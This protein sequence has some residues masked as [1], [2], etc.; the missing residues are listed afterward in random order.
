MKKNNKLTFFGV[1]CFMLLF[2]CLQE[3]FCAGYDD[4]HYINDEALKMVVKIEND[5]ILKSPFFLKLPLLQMIFNI[6]DKNNFFMDILSFLRNR[7][8]SQYSKKKKYLE[9]N[10]KKEIDD[11][12][13]LSMSYI[14]ARNDFI[15]YKYM[16]KEKLNKVKELIEEIKKEVFKKISFL[17]SSWIGDEIIKA[18]KRNYAL[19][20]KK[21]IFDLNNEKSVLEKKLS[22]IKDISFFKELYFSIYKDEKKQSEKEA[23]E[24]EEKIKKIKHKIAVIKF[25]KKLK[26]IEDLMAAEKEERMI[27]EDEKKCLIF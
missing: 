21:E 27:Y 7:G 17:S 3:N 5:S 9:Y 23:E 22:K 2:F 13:W 26:N 12:L 16:N 1:S 4:P 20:V 25:E 24:I 19:N 10:M 18:Y 11:F 14:N 8:D 15:S 6:F